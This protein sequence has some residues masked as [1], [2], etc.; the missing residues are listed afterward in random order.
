MYVSQMRDCS[1]TQY[2]GGTEVLTLFK[3]FNPGLFCLDQLLIARMLTAT[4]TK[5][6]YN[7]LS[8]IGMQSPHKQM[9]TLTYSS[10]IIW[11]F[12]LIL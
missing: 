7:W 3:I 8:K 9:H 1:S 2:E 4:K 5:I 11:S 6:L 12:Y 10:I